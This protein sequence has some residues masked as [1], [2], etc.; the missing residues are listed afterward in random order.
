MSLK[1]SGWVLAKF[2]VHFLAM[3]L[4]CTGSGHHPLPPVTRGLVQAGLDTVVRV[5]VDPLEFP[6]SDERNHWQ[7]G[8]MCAK[9]SPSSLARSLL[10]YLLFCYSL[11]FND[12]FLRKALRSTHHRRSHRCHR[13]P[14]HWGRGYLDFSGNM[15]STLQALRHFAQ[16][17]PSRNILFTFGM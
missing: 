8:Q 13:V 10:S 6:Y 14:G 1:Y 12:D 15:L 9:E 17:L 11:L 3:Y 16:H 7:I 4:Q 5:S 2:F